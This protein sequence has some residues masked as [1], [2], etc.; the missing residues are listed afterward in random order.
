LSTVALGFGQLFLFS[1]ATTTILFIHRWY[2]GISDSNCLIGSSLVI[3]LRGIALAPLSAPAS[4]QG[5]F[6]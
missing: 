1:L 5:S 4:V 6:R 3:L 2:L